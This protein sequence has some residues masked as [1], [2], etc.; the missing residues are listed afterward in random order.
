MCV[1]VHE[2]HLRKY[3]PSPTLWTLAEIWL[4][5]GADPRIAFLRKSSIETEEMHKLD[6]RLLI[7]MDT[8]DGVNIAVAEEE[9]D[10][11]SPT[12]WTLNPP[13]N[14]HSSQ[15]RHLVPLLAKLFEAHGGGFSMEDFVHFLNPPNCEKLLELMK[16]NRRV[17]DEAD[18]VRAEKALNEKPTWESL[19]NTTTRKLSQT[20]AFGGF[21]KG[22]LLISESDCP[23]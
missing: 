16:R 21:P 7:T 10:T 2:N 1:K 9:G 4:E 17:C 6:R 13:Q 20:V 19:I 15:N 22:W 18:R 14:Q 8:V 23:F 11:E 3:E 12:R 5:F